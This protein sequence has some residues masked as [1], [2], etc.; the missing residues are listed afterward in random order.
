MVRTMKARLEQ[1]FLAKMRDPLADLDEMEADVVA[2][3]VKVLESEARAGSTAGFCH[4]LSY[5]TKLQSGFAGVV[6]VAGVYEDEL[7]MTQLWSRQ[8][9]SKSKGKGNVAEP[10]SAEGFASE[11]DRIL[12]AFHF[13]PL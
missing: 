10:L 3:V 6:G 8:D 9:E 5:K 12:G 2:T 13:I 11:M 4:A 1:A 7:K